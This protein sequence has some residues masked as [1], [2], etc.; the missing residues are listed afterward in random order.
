MNME[1]VG[2]N[3][4]RVELDLLDIVCKYHR[5]KRVAMF[6]RWIHQ[7][8]QRLIRPLAEGRNDLNTGVTVELPSRE[9]LLRMSAMRAIEDAN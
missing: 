1:R 7:E 4:S 3:L 5:V 2:F 6:R 9:E 8:S